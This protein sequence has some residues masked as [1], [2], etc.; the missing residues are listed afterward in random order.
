MSEKI[1]FVSFE[2]FLADKLQ[3]P[4]FK[5]AYEALEPAY[6]VAR[7]RLAKGLTQAEL[8]RLADTKQSS[9]ARL[10]SGKVQPTLPLLRKIAK[11]LGFRLNIDFEPIEEAG[12]PTSERPRHQAS[13]A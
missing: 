12:D 9:I 3:D 11:A 2:E 13:H 7:L 10:E 6:E 8:A 5:E 1:G 4:E